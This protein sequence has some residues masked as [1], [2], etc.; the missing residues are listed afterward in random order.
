MSI[1]DGCLIVGKTNGDIVACNFKRT[2][3]VRK[4]RVSLEPIAGACWTRDA[5]SG[6]LLAHVVSGATHLVLDVFHYSRDDASAV[7]VA[8]RADMSSQFG[9]G[10]RRKRVD[11]LRA[12]EASVG[13]AASPD[14]DAVARCDAYVRVDALRTKDGFFEAKF[15]RGELVRTHGSASA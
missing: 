13:A 6:A 10:D 12:V 11:A 3:V 5:A 4:R 2:N 1:T 7:F 8:T 15:W 14:A 9:A